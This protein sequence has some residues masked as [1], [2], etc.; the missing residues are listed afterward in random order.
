MLSL[1]LY[2]YI[3][4]TQVPSIYDLCNHCLLNDR[5]FFSGDMPSSSDPVCRRY[6]RFLIAVLLICAFLVTSLAQALIIS[7]LN[8]GTSPLGGS[9]LI[10]LYTFAKVIV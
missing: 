7:H 5:I 4:I 2:F 1:L 10:C 6:Y 8:Y 3:E 9:P